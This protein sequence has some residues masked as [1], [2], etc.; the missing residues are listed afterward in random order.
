MTPCG[1]HQVQETMIGTVPYWLLI[2]DKC[3][4]STRET[5]NT[6][7]DWSS[8][9]VNHHVKSKNFFAK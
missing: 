4:C 9:F 5:V 3:K 7:A 8:G 1:T 6:A 2:D